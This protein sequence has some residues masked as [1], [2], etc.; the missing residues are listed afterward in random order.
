MHT[1]RR[2]YLRTHT[3]THIHTR[4]HTHTHTHTRFGQKV[5][6]TSPN[7][8]VRS[9]LK[10]RQFRFIIDSASCWIANFRRSHIKRNLPLASHQDKKKNCLKTIT[11]IILYNITI[12]YMSITRH[13]I[14]L[15]H[16]FI[17]IAAAQAIWFEIGKFTTNSRKLSR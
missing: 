17:I 6:L 1:S 15:H 13:L 16:C 10:L 14:V 12:C 11:N 5:S 8:G 2:P 3:H 4:T 7:K 9:S